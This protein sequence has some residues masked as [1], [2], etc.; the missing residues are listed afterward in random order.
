MRQR[1]ILVVESLGSTP[2]GFH[3]EGAGMG[4]SAESTTRSK[5]TAWPVSLK[6]QK[7]M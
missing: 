2:S 3:G 5:S 7:M 1:S 4:S 6:L